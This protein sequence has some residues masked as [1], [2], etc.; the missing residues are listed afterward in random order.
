MDEDTNYQ[1]ECTIDETDSEGNTN[2]C[3]CYAVD[4]EGNYVD[5]C[6]RPV[7][8]CCAALQR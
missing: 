5:P 3:C 7:S 1:S 8:N 6:Y 4:P 2:L